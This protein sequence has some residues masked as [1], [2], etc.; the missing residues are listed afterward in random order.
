MSISTEFRCVEN[1]KSGPSRQFRT[2]SRIDA[3]NLPTA[4][5]DIVSAARDAVTIAILDIA[6]W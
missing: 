2:H 3:E 4:R 1:L 5:Y 6:L